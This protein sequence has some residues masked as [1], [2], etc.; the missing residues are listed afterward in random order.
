LDT[1]ITVFNEEKM[2]VMPR[3]PSTHVITSKGIFLILKDS[4]NSEDF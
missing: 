4:Q 2:G 1:E 3:N